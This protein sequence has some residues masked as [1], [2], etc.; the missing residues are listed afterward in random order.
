MWAAVGLCY[1]GWTP[2]AWKLFDWSQDG[3]D[4]FEAR[5]IA[6]YNRG[7]PKALAEMYTEDLRF[8][9]DG[10]VQEGRARMEEAWRG[11]AAAL[12]DVKLTTV[13]RV[14]R[15]DVGVLTQRFTQR[16]ERQRARR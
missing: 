10:T 9:L 2:H 15:G 12:S 8:I 1:P 14:I 16:T 6:A 4:S 3:V 11:N 5:L 7:D 13:E